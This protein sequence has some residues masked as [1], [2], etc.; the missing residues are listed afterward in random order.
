[1]KK[2]GSKSLELLLSAV[3][4]EEA[5]MEGVRAGNERRLKDQGILKK[6]VIQD[7]FVYLLRTEEGK[8]SEDDMIKLAYK[9][10]AFSQLLSGLTSGSKYVS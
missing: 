9:P 7:G 10:R 1:M 2:P 4:K 5:G 3:A 8:G 6:A